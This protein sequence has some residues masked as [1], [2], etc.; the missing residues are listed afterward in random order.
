MKKKKGIIVSTIVMLGLLIGFGGF[1][2]AYFTST[3]TSSNNTLSTGTMMV[4]LSDTNET[5]QA[6]ISDSWD[7]SNLVPGTQL[8]QSRIEVYN[9]GSVNAQHLDIQFSYTGD[10]DLAKNIIFNNV[11]TG[12]RFGGSSGSDSSTINLT[13]ALLGVPDTEY[14]AKQAANGQPFTATTVDGIDGTIPDSKISL[15]ELAA[16]G[17]I[18]LEKGTQRGAIDA[19]TAADLHLNA[20]VGP[21]LIAQGK[22]LD[23][24]ITF[25]ID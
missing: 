12:F 16:F 9:A 15:S 22:S 11:G 6:A 8:P 17:K 10:A 20:I 18:R 4:V 24:I 5:Q 23:V 25:T 2:G 7:G 3:A 14:F 1:S 19:G 13:T 21:D